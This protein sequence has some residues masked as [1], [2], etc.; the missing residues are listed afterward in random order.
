[1]LCIPS[2]VSRSFE[3]TCRLHLQILKLLLPASYLFFLD[4]FFDPEDG[5]DILCY[6]PEDWT[7]CNYRCESISFYTCSFLGLWASFRSLFPIPRRYSSGWALASWTICLH[8]RLTVW[9]LNNL[10]LIVWGCQPHVQ[11]PTWRT[12]IFLFVWLLLLDL[13]GMGYP[14]SSYATAGIALRVSGALKPHH[15]NKVETPSVGSFVP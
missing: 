14:T 6:I 2:K 10:V 11:P 9:F 15:H 5:G 12:R 7:L 3:W 4:V 8:S 1:M 13:S